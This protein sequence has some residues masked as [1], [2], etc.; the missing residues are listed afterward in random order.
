[1]R[2]TLLIIFCCSFL[3][4]SAQFGKYFKNRT[5]RYDYYHS[6]SYD[7]EYI[8]ADELVTEGK[9][10]GPKKGLIDPF[11]YGSHRM[12]VY[13]EGSSWL[14]FSRNY[15]SLFVEYQATEEAKSQCGNFPES[16]LMPLPKKP[17]LIRFES[18]GIDQVWKT[19]FETRLDPSDAGI[20]KAGKS[21]YPAVTVH[22]SG[23]PTKKLDIV[24]LPEGYTAEEM[25]KFTA[26]CRRFAGYLFDTE[27]YGELRDRINITAVLAP[28]AQSG[29]DI[30][31][32]SVFRET[33]LHSSFNTFNTERYLTT[34]DFKSVR[35]AASGV[36]YDHI[37]ILVNDDLYG[38]G[39]IYNFYA[40]TTVDDPNSGFVFTH[41]FGH[42]FAGLGDEYSG[43]GSN[44]EDLYSPAYEPWEPNITTL[45]EFTKKWQDMLPSGTP[46]PTPEGEEWQGKLGVFEGGGYMEKG[47]Y[48]PWLDCSMNVVRFN[49]FCPVC[50][51]AIRD[52]I[53]GYW[54]GK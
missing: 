45:A 51:R 5:L 53:T 9:W 11:D 23:K 3:V 28:S 10:A 21:V 37:V 44:S 40:I 50:Q 27:P 2:Y 7:A 25:E 15:S 13:D 16:I 39:G 8:M 34:A 46:V 54:S 47:V 22:S 30:P 14:I 35:N 43:S 1:M 18:R 20:R 12:M 49:N 41:E 6:G 48:R 4:S 32:D 29:T 24:F 52:V 33:L 36:P 17:V 42:S 31:Q 38:G 19:V 26:D